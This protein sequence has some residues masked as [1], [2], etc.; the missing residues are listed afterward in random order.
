MMPT[1]LRGYLLADATV[2]GLVVARVFPVVIPQGTLFPAVAYQETV[3]LRFTSLDGPTGLAQWRMSFAAF[4]ETY[5]A[6]KDVGDAVRKR[7]DGKKNFVFGSTTFGA[8]KLE[9]EIDGFEQEAG[10]EASSPGLHRVVQDY[11]ITFTES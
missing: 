3:A 9:G 2:A 5:Q 1:D 11:L 8:I 7:F 6:V 10:S 4:A